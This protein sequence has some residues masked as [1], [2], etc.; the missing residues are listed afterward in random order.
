[1]SEQQSN[2]LRGWGVMVV[3]VVPTCSLKVDQPAQ[4]IAH[5]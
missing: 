5:N 3:V 4:Q 2:D 1:M